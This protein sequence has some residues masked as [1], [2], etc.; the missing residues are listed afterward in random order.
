VHTTGTSTE[1]SI[2]GQAGATPEGGP[3]EYT[4][5]AC[6]SSANS[7]SFCTMSKMGKRRERAERRREWMMMV[8][9][10]IAFF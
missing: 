3:K 5:E 8:R 4:A 9:Q 10:I 7:N 2:S 6:K 1:P